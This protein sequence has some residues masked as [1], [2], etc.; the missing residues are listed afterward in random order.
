MKRNGMKRGFLVVLAVILVCACGGAMA[1]GTAPTESGLSFQSDQLKLSFTLPAGWMQDESPDQYTFQSPDEN[2]VIRVVP[3]DSK[4][5]ESVVSGFSE[6]LLR[7][8]LEE[9]GQGEFTDIQTLFFAK[10]AD[11]DG[12]LYAI[13]AHGFTMNEAQFIYLWYYFTATDGT[14][15]AVVGISTN[16]GAGE[17]MLTWFDEMT[18][19]NIPADVYAR[20]LEQLGM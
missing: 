14:L 4:V 2:G 8:G 11:A 18:R 12:N 9:E 1:E 6:E 16:D 7:E 13:C 19:T 20:L 15:G 17:A 10:T 3:T 5:T